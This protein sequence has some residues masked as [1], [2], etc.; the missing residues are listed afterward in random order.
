MKKIFALTYQR[1][2]FREVMLG[3]LLVLV[4]FLVLF[5]FFDLIG[6]LGDIGKGG[7]QF[8]HALIFVLLSLPG[9]AY[10]LMP[11]AVL[12]GALYALSTLARHSEITVLRASGMST[13]DLLGA[14]FRVAGVFALVTFLIGEFVAPPAEQM[15]QEVRLKA[16][17]TIVASDFRTGLWV[18][19]GQSFINVAQVLP[20]TRLLGIRIYEFDAQRHLVSVSDA[21]EGE[22]VPPDAW[23]L[24]GVVRTFVDANGGRVQR[25]PSLTWKSALNPD[26]LSVLLVVPERMSVINLVTYLKHLSVNHQKTQRYQIALWKKI[27]YPLAGFVMVALALPFGYT[28]DRV[29]GVSLRIFGGVMLGVFFHMLNGLFANLGVINSW[30]PFSSAVA[31]SALFLLAASA[32][33]WW[34]E[35]R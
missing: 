1:Y 15:A 33:I 32:M 14:L 30:P 20:D 18:K 28:H 13:R 7:F 2:L 22:Y 11:I 3:T 26:I 12:I 9:R 35:R 16:M 24:N 6:E 31:P 8:H 29:G 17:G 10:E 25:L 23:R 5:G 21:K 4:A 19:D 34:V 27:I